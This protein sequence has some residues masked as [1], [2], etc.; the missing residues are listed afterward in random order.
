MKNVMKKIIFVLCLMFTLSQA[1]AYKKC[2]L[3]SEISFSAQRFEGN[4]YLI[5]AVKADKDKHLL[6]N[7]ILKFL[8]EDD[9]VLRLESTNGSTRNRVS[10]SGYVLGMG[11]VGSSSTDQS[12]SYLMFQLTDEQIEK[13]QKGVKAAVVNTIPEMYRVKVN[14]KKFSKQILEILTNIEEDDENIIIEL[15]EDDFVE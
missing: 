14:N 8:L 12:V 5:M 4:T 3:C 2:S 11:L 1:F 7:T 10:S 15:P 9:S 6:P 13:F